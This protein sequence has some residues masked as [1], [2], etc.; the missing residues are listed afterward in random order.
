[1]QF[2][3]LGLPSGLPPIT[4]YLLHLQRLDQYFAAIYIELTIIVG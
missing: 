3:R 2:S 4:S 1:V